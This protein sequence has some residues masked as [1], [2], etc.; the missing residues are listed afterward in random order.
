MA[1]ERK[2]LPRPPQPAARDRVEALARDCFAKMVTTQPTSVT[3]TRIAE[4]AIEA[5]TA[6]YLTWDTKDAPAGARS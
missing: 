6:F 5:A 3:L 1:E 2:P 4:V